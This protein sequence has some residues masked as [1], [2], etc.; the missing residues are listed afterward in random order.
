M[1]P[2]LDALTLRLF[3]QNQFSI[4]LGLD[5]MRR[6][7]ALA[8]HPQRA[9]PC[10]LIAGTNGKGT[11]A[12]LL[13]SLLHRDAAPIGLYTS[14]HLVH[15]HERFRLHN[16]PVST[17]HLLPVLAAA[18]AAFAGPPHLPPLLHD[19]GL[20][21]ARDLGWDLHPDAPTLTFFEL[22]TLIALELF[23]QHRARLAVLEIGLGGRL[24]AV[25]AVDPALAAVTSI[26]LDHQQYLGDTLALIAAEKAAIA[27]PNIPLLV[28]PQHPDALAAIQQ[29]AHRIGAPIL[30]PKPLDPTS[31]PPW[32]RGPFADNAATAIALY[33]QVHALQLLPGTK[34]SP[35]EPDLQHLRWPARRDEQHLA[36]RP[37]CL[38][39]AHNPDGIRS[40]AA[41]LRDRPRP[42][43]AWGILGLMRDK[44]VH[45]VCRALASLP[46]RWIVTAANTPRALE[47]DA[48]ADALRDAGA[49][50]HATAP[51]LHDALHLLPP[52]PHAE[53]LALGSVY[54]L[55]ELLAALHAPP[56]FFSLSGRLVPTDPGAYPAEG[57]HTQE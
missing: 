20:R 9:F 12:S 15:L 11:T 6:A 54:L 45:N 18:L 40:A 16:R 4:K 24:D 21:A 49:Q 23:R 17:P 3:S 19:L 34:P 8:Q 50:V 52:D 27:R 26:S 39:V 32:L 29:T 38:D 2:D 53:I 30:H 51:N 41:F 7:L 47:P 22:T 42:I 10:V 56:A 13:A 43:P 33:H 36:G 25:N 5:N 31:L 37:W 14:P 57:A 55:G 28:A 35:P 46:T 44:D 48:L 1:N